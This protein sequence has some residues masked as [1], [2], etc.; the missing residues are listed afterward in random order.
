MKTYF[1]YKVVWLFSCL[2]RKGLRNKRKACAFPASFLGYLHCPVTSLQNL[3]AF[4]FSHLQVTD[5]QKVMVSPTTL[6][7]E[8]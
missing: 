4:Q 3:W 2:Y 5:T 1:M 7:G 6:N 8:T